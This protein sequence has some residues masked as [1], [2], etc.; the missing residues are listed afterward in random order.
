MILLVVYQSPLAACK[1][2]FFF[3]FGW[4]SP[5]SRDVL[6]VCSSLQDSESLLTSLY[7][8]ASLMTF[9]ISTRS[10][11]RPICNASKP[12]S[13]IIIPSH[14]V[15]RFLRCR[16]GSTSNESPWQLSIL[17]NAKNYGNS[18]SC[19]HFNV[20][21]A[22]FSPPSSPLTPSIVLMRVLLERVSWRFIYP[23]QAKC[24]SLTTGTIGSSWLW[25]IKVLVSWGAKR[26]NPPSL[27]TCLGLI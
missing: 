7:R 6:A 23:N 22:G 19:P 18:T 17:S 11:T 26:W 9:K 2:F 8:S 27:C 5:F 24:Q 10:L 25:W 4:P 12:I 1:V 16:D 14:S 20:I 13:T 21:V 15:T 3:F